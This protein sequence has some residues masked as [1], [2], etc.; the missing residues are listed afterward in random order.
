MTWYSL[1]WR[2]DAVSGPSRVMWSGNKR[3]DSRDGGDDFSKLELVEDG[4]LTGGVKSDH[5]NS[6]STV[7]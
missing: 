1:R 2:S 5:E 6:C 3:T 4:G 7:Q